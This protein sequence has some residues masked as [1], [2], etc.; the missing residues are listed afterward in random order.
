MTAV[1]ALNRGGSLTL[2]PGFKDMMLSVNDEIPLDEKKPDKFQF[3]VNKY[4]NFA[5]INLL[6]V[7]LCDTD[8]IIMLIDSCFPSV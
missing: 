6:T 2:K 3:I 8:M 5:A 4:A 7:M 1:R